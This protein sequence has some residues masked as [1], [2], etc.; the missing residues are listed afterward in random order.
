ML[1]EMKDRWGLKHTILL[2]H[3][4]CKHGRATFFYDVT[5]LI[6]TNEGQDQHNAPYTSLQP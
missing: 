3:R 5:N 1:H 4:H 6:F 2:I